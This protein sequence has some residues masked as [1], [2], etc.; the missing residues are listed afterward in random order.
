M[1]DPVLPRPT[2]AAPSPTTAPSS[3]GFRLPSAAVL[4]GGV[5]AV[6]VLG[7]LAV[8]TGQVLS[9]DV[10]PSAPDGPLDSITAIGT[11]GTAALLV[12]VGLALW[13]RGTRERSRVGAVLLAALSLLTLLV[14]WSGTP[15]V[16]GACAAWLAGLTRG[17]RPLSGAARAAGLVGLLVAALNV[18]LTVGGFV[19]EGVSG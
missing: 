14:F 15:G 3:E 17:R 13:L 5:Y 16:L 10:D 2:T 18:L 9:T 19:L 1:S 7:P 11:V 12:G 6:C 8:F 4:V